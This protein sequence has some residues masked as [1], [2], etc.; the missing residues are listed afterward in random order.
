MPKACWRLSTD[1]LPLT[2]VDNENGGSIMETKGGIRINYGF[3]AC[4]QRRFLKESFFCFNLATWIRA[5]SLF[6]KIPPLT[7]GET[8]ANPVGSTLKIL[9]SAEFLVLKH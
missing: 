3:P 8:G 6:S 4:Q 9:P 1:S 7:S 2:G 5:C